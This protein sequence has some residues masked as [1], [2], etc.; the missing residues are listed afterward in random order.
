MQLQRI[1]THVGSLDEVEL[2]F[3]PIDA[4]L[5]AA[6]AKIPGLRTLA[7]WLAYVPTLAWR[8]RRYDALHVFTAAYWGY[9]LWVLP[10]LVIARLWR[11][12]ILV[13]Y[14]DG[15]ADDHL[16]HWRWARPTLGWMDALVV[17]SGFLVD[18]FARHGLVAEV[19]PNVIDPSRFTYRSRAQMAPVLL[20]NR[21]LEPLYNVACTLRAFRL[22]QDRYPH[23][24]FLVAHDG[25]ER[26]TLEALARE[27]D[28]RHITFTGAVPQDQIA[29]QY[30]AADI[31][32]T[33]PN[34]DNMPLS[35][36]EC[37]ASGLPIV[38][39]AAGGIPYLVTHERTALLVPINDHE[40]VAA[41]CLRLLGDPAL[42]V[43]L[44]E[45]AFADVQRYRGD[46]VAR[47]WLATYQ[48]L[49]SRRALTVGSTSG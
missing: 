46:A 28:L 23:A 27:L 3:H 33:T 44:A 15:Q 16:T 5:P 19:V 37:A 18:V 4:V 35:L 17:P 1:L 24:R 29:A 36:L 48:R 7:R 39:T 22:V 13:N 40:A 32:V 34:I 9:Y 47:E 38:A 21:A 43:R 26:P 12:P 31:Y 14:H 41:A 8:A 11:I 30:N 10:A 49:T 45:A 20:Q 2:G 25:P 42:G 6:L